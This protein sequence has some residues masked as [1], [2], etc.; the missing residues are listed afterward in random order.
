MKRRVCILICLALPQLLF[1]Q[2]NILFIIKDIHSGD[3]LKGASVVI[4]GGERGNKTDSAGRILFHNIPAGR[5]TFVITYSGYDE[6]KVTINFPLTVADSVVFISMERE[7]KEMQQV[8]VNSSRTDTRIENA[9]TRVEVLGA[10]EVD[11]ESG[12]HP[13]NIASLLGDVAGIQSQNLSAATSNT[14]LRIQG[15]PGNYTQILRDGVP[16]FGGYAG[17]FS[18]LQ[19]PPLD[20]KQIEIIKGPN[21][22]LY[23]GGA[24]AGLINIISRKPQPNERERYLLLNQ[25][26]LQETNL[27]LY[28][29]ERIKKTAY[30]FF[31][32]GNYQKQK[33]INN[34][35]FSD[36]PRVENA[37]VHPTFF[38]YPNEKNTIS[39]GINSVYEDRKGGDMDILEGYYSNFHQFFIQDQTLRNTLDLDWNYSFSK[40]DKFT[41]KATTSSFNRSISTNVFGMK[42]KQL[43]WYSEASWLRKTVKHD[44]VAGLNLNGENWKKELPDSTQLTNYNY[45]TV[46]LF[47]QDDWR[48]HPKF[49]IESGLRADFHNR[50]GT[51]VLPR[52]SLL[53]KPANTVS[54][55]LGGGLGYK[56]PTVFENDIDER[57]YGKIQPLQNVV[58]ERSWG[59]NF[60]INFRKRWDELVLAI[61]QSFF[62]T[63]INH[64]LVMQATPTAI[65]FYTAGEPLVTK[66]TESWLQVYWK[67]LQAYVGF[68]YTDAHKKYDPLFPHEEFVAA[69]KFASIISYEVVKHFTIALEASYTGQQFLPGGTQ[70]PSF[71]IYAAMLRYETGRVIFVLN[72]EN[73]N[74]YRQT[75][76]E[77]IVIPPLTNPTFKPIWASLEGRVFNLSIRIALYDKQKKPDQD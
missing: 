61:N 40:Q 72:G 22:T 26:S 36:L 51:F 43:S 49:I 46:G 24:I 37:F 70:T 20:L 18:I 5:Q 54:M 67:K 16:L 39:L 3:S 47:V 41:L 45:V 8:I 2:N 10:E 9:P 11:E 21:S 33:D 35:N 17:S 14:E 55:R 62:L 57:D 19:I 74:D 69:N 42:A 59:A 28:L 64:P 48:L 76:K 31:A 29:S 15:L 66:G 63:Q 75:K 30:S 4:R 53:Y 6:N 44:I 60:D 71:P 34:D 7:E 13:S 27:Q 65:S 38:F 56:I 1:S 73:L 52:L 58:A 77:D 32:G 50:Y 68:T 25:S 23:G 12:I